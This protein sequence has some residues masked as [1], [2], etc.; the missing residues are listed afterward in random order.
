MNDANEKLTTKTNK[1]LGIVLSCIL[2][3]G[4][5]AGSVTMINKIDNKAE[6]AILEDGEQN[7]KIES[8]AGVVSENSTSIKLH[9]QRLD[10]YD[11]RIKEFKETAEKFS[12]A[13]NEYVRMASV[14]SEQIKQ[15]RSNMEELKR[16]KE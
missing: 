12:N 11:K 14:L 7:I 1:I 2:I 4:Y 3:V 5:I 16:D 15:L 6:K 9:E 8:I 10:S 13:A